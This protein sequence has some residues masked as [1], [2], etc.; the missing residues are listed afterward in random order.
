MCMQVH[1]NANKS[2][3]IPRQC[4][5]AAI[6]QMVMDGLRYTL[7][8]AMRSERSRRPCLLVI[9]NI[10]Q[11]VRPLVRGIKNRHLIGRHNDITTNMAALAV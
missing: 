11:S 3:T 9:F 1:D 2:S 5:P 6:T 7:A 10:F 8:D 4:H